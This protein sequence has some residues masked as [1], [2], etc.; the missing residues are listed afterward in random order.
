MA[1]ELVDGHA[2]RAHIDSSDLAALNVGTIGAESCVLAWGG[3][4]TLQMQSASSG[5]VS[6]GAGVVRGRRFVAHT[7]TQVSIMPGTQAERRHDLVVARYAKS[8]DVESVSLVVVRGTP[9]EGEPTDPEV[10]E[11]DLPLWRVPLDGISVGAPQR[12]SEPVRTLSSLAEAVE[13]AGREVRSMHTWPGLDGL[14][15]WRRGNIVTVTLDGT[16]NFADEWATPL[17][18]RLP[19][20][21]APPATVRTPV[22]ATNQT[23]HLAVFMNVTDA[24]AV[25]VYCAGGRN[26]GSGYTWRGTLTYAARWA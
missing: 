5:T 23:E 3:G 11:G 20:G 21:W 1:V 9:T 2:G 6:T 22:S 17:T 16:V 24:G 8:G 25:E 15:A 18:V 26:P 12:L 4:L 14:V 7:P 13:E 10:A 19:D